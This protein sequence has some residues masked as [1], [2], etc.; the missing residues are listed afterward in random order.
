MSMGAR[1]RFT[2]P[3]CGWPT[4]SDFRSDMLEPVGLMSP[5][6]KSQR[7]WPPSAAPQ[8]TAGLN[9]GRPAVADRDETGPACVPLGIPLWGPT[10]FSF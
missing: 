6:D 2:A 4:A 7:F 1:P 8:A 9:T 5:S 3:S 10:C